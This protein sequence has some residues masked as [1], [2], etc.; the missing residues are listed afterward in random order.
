ML[1]RSYT[2]H[3]EK[4]CVIFARSMYN[5]QH[6]VTPEKGVLRVQL[7]C[8]RPDVEIRYTVDGSEP[9]ETSMLYTHPLTVKDSRTINCAT[10]GAGR[11]LGKT[12][13]LPVKWNKATAKPILGDKPN[14]RV[15]TNGIRGRRKHTDF[16]WCGWPENDSVTFTVDLQKEEKMK[17]VTIG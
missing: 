15:L 8:I 16:E 4:R 10:F 17:A 5:I 11:Q 13:A 14:E 1:F 6:T 2:A 12:L 9:T 7:E 3:L